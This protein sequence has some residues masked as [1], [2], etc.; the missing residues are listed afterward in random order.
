M[1]S[2]NKYDAVMAY[3]R[4]QMVALSRTAC[5]SSV[6]AVSA[7]SPDELGLRGTLDNASG[8]VVVQGW[9]GSP[10]CALHGGVEPFCA[11]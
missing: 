7:H 1:S 10:V 3:T 2:A 5:A 11:G 6:D 4:E 9:P 8:I